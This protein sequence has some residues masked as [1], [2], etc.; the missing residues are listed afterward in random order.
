MKIERKRCRVGGG[1]RGR[2]NIDTEKRKQ[3]RIEEKRR[4]GD[5]RKREDGR[6]GT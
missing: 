3:K 2:K 4:D 5:K 1:D 6:E